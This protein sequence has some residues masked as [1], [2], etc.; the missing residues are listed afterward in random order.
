[1]DERVR[2]SDKIVLGIVTLFF[3][4]IAVVACFANFPWGIFVAMFIFLVWALVLRGYTWVVVEARGVESVTP[5][6]QV[7]S[8]EELEEI[9]FDD[10]R[11]II[12][13]SL[14]PELENPGRILTGAQKP[15]SDSRII[16]G[17]T[18]AGGE[19]TEP[20]RENRDPKK[21]EDREWADMFR[22]L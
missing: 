12:D 17:P 7:T 13:P 2:L 4:F 9:P 5:R 3:G 8:G 16:L 6:Y 22:A 19:L 11:W 1:M 20:G 15:V 14:P 21:E 10:P 18:P